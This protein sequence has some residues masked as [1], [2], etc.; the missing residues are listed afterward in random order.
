MTL[1]E[2]L[3][4]QVNLIAFGDETT[5]AIDEEDD[6]L[7]WSKFVGFFADLLDLL[8]ARTNANGAFEWEHEDIWNELSACIRGCRRSGR[9]AGLRCASRAARCRIRDQRCTRCRIGDRFNLAQIKRE[10]RHVARLA[11]LLNGEHKHLRIAFDNRAFH[12]GL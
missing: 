11:T 12:D 2:F 7:S 6:D 10:N 8:M 5:W 4:R 9:R 1:L 3:H